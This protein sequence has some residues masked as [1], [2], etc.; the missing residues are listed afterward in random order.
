LKT[1]WTAVLLATL[2][3]TICAFESQLTVTN[4]AYIVGSLGITPDEFTWIIGGFLASVLIGVVVTDRL[5]NTLGTRN[6]LLSCCA[7]YVGFELLAAWSPECMPFALSRAGAGFVNGMMTTAS[8]MLIMRKAAP[9]KRLLLY[10]FFGAPTIFVVPFSLLIGG[11]LIE[12]TGTWRE[13]Y[14]FAA[15]PGAALFC[16]FFCLLPPTQVR[17]NPLTRVDWTGFF[18]VVASAV[19]Y[20]TI[21]VRGT[22]ENWLDSPFIQF[23]LAFNVM[24]WTALAFHQI[25]SRGRALKLALL[26]DVHVLSVIALNAIFGFILSYT[27]VVIGFLVLTQDANSAQIGFA[28]AWAGV[29][30][31]FVLSRFKN[32]DHR[33]LMV[34]GAALFFASGLVNANLTRLEDGNDLLLSQVLRS[35]GQTLFLWPLWNLTILD[36]PRRDY[37]SAAKLYTFSRTIGTVTGVGAVGAIELWR[38]NA[39]SVHITETLNDPVFHAMQSHLV[40]Y[41]VAHGSSVS[42]ASRQ[43]LIAVTKHIRAESLVL[44]YSDTF[45]LIGVSVMAALV[46]LLFVR[47]NTGPSVYESAKAYF[48]GT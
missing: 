14:E 23:L 12:S 46:P 32:L 47:S 30:A 36:T 35:F 29:T 9:D 28:V 48:H 26:A 31:P 3:T 8:L 10:F 16:A 37:D 13:M 21:M 45:W 6:F 34:A 33:L 38:Q 15:L 43:A 5:L 17:A 4:A 42:Q 41:F 2:G 19:S 27:L 24:S 1:P 40:Q 20:C 22:T 11:T 7:L 25:Q 18:L 44:T 39:H